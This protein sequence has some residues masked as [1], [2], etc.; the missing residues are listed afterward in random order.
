[1]MI[2]GGTCKGYVEDR[3]ESDQQECSELHV[4]VDDRGMIIMGR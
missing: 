3:Q 1:V 4:D 2:I